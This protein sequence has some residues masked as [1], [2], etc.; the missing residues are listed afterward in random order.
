MSNTQLLA[1]LRAK[2]ESDLG[3]MVFREDTARGADIVPPLSDY[4][5]DEEAAAM[6]AKILQIERDAIR[7][8]GDF[9]S[10][11]ELSALSSDSHSRTK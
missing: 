7:A 10:L 2:Q 1:R 4:P 11:H 9:L 5:S 8:S 3:A 6:T